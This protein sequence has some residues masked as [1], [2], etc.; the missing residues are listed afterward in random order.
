MEPSAAT[1]TWYYTDDGG[2]ERGPLPTAQLRRLVLQGFVVGPRLVKH[3]ASG[4][5]QDV[6]LWAELIEPHDEDEE[7]RPSGDE[8]SQAEID[9]WNVEEGEWVFIDD[10]GNVQGPFGTAEMHEWVRQ[11]YLEPTREVN[12]AG[13]ERDDFR[14]LREWGELAVAAALLPQMATEHAPVPHKSA[15]VGETLTA[16]DRGHAAAAD[17]NSDGA[18]GDGASRAD[19]GSSAVGSSAVGNSAVGNSAVG[20]SAVGSSDVGN[21]AV[22]S[23]AVGSSAVGNSAVGSTTYGVGGGAAA[24]TGRETTEAGSWFF[25]DDAGAVQGPFP[26]KRMR[27]WLRKGMLN[28]DRICRRAEEPAETAQPG[29]VAPSAPDEWKPALSWPALVGAAAAVQ[30]MTGAASAAPATELAAVGVAVGVAV[31]G[32]ASCG[33]PLP[34][35]GV[36]T[37]SAAAVSSAGATSPSIA[38][39]ASAA[40]TDLPNMDEALWEYVDDH[41]RLQGPFTARKLLGWLRAGHLKRTRRAR[42]YVPDTAPFIGGPGEAAAA[43][44]KRLDE[45]DWFAAALTGGALPAAPVAPP[46]LTGGGGTGA[47]ET[48]LWFYRDVAHAEQG[49]F[50]A[51]A[52]QQWIAHGLLPLN[53]SVRHLSE[54]AGR[55]RPLSEIPLLVGT[56]SP[57]ANI[58]TASETPGAAAMPPIAAP[59]IGTR[60]AAALAALGQ[61]KTVY[62]DYVV[63]GGFNGVGD[64]KF[65]PLDRSGD[66]YWEMKGIPKHRDERQMGHYF[67]L[68]AWQEERNRQTLAQQQKRSRK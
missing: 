39:N 46:Q 59:T 22:G 42:L 2:I 41:G 7:E 25:V 30:R 61:S 45:W 1:D 64:R 48:P 3:V 20:S 58:A 14:P 31:G 50:T 6:S 19:V 51:T 35:V 34:V 12:V 40:T 44:L 57:H 24:D 16:V 52:M 38:G 56:G 63:L 49:P 65:A 62:E 43:P 8:Q 15:V 55:Y 18:S 32:A 27:G 29:A 17:S 66:K 13:G 53:T 68:G 67:D 47:V 28:G 37:S 11:G 9:E 54:G 10:E 4:V 23:S 5:V 60:S 26:T 36:A 33:A 21:S